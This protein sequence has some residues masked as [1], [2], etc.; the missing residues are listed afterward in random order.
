M[1]QL[2][3][4]LCKIHG[5]NYCHLVGSA[6]SGLYL[7]I[8]GLELQGRTIAIPNSVCHHVPL[9][10]LLSGNKPMYL[11]IS[12]E[13]LGIDIDKLKSNADKIDAVIAVH[14]YGSTCNI[15]AIACFCKFRGIPLIEDIA[16]A[17]GAKIDGYPVGI[18][19]DI[20]VASFGSGKIIDCGHGGA[21][22]TNDNALLKRAISHEKH[23]V[24]YKELFKEALEA[25]DK[26]HTNLYNNYYGEKIN[27]HCTSFK[28][29][30]L[31]L[32]QYILY[33][34]DLSYEN[35]I[36]ERL[37]SLEKIIELRKSRS[38]MFRSIFSSSNAAVRLF[39]PRHGSVD[40]RFNIFIKN[41][42]AILKLLLVKKF[43]VSSWF[44]SVDLF[45]ENRTFTKINTVVSDRVGD[46]IL[47][48]W[49]NEDVGNEYIKAIT[50]E[51]IL[52][53]K[54]SD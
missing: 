15:S 49:V 50:N 30:A 6:T 3:K 41:R 24:A 35:I 45:F 14:A 46:E 28:K 10:I 12:E 47:N 48:L 42:D 32:R 18:F 54:N 38:E 31:F 53:V 11:D 25:F 23:F 22:L 2:E 36:L 43:K 13:D 7:A 20:A 44:P 34:F 9:A 8:L 19:S 51:I 33:K 4:L 5:K 37:E 17:Q 1:R 29:R 39:N 52:L 16:V 40:W 27:F 21:L 26:Y